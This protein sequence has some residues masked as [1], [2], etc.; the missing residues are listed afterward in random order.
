MLTDLGFRLLSIQLNFYTYQMSQ[1]SAFQSLVTK[2]AQEVSHIVLLCQRCAP[3][4][5]VDDLEQR[6]SVL[7]AQCNNIIREATSEINR[8]SDLSP[9]PSLADVYP[10]DVIVLKERSASK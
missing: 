1:E 3:S 9:T 2:N 6:I 8:T 5:H 7:E 10:S 4:T